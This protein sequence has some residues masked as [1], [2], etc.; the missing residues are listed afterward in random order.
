MNLGN[1]VYNWTFDN[2]GVLTLPNGGEIDNDSNNIQDESTGLIEGLAGV[3]YDAGCWQARAVAQRVETA[4]AQANYAFFFQ[5]ELGGIA[6][7]GNNPLAL[8]SR[9]IPGYV[10]SS[11]LNNNLQSP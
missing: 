8:L 7:I 5:L 1:A 10:S 4:T 11:M 3:E 9:S 2:T 6:S